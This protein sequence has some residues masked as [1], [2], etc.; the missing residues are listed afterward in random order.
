MTDLRSKY[1]P[2]IFILSAG[3]LLLLS[4]WIFLENR[5]ITQLEDML[6]ET[7]IELGRARLE[8]AR[9]R[10]P[11]PSAGEPPE[12]ENTVPDRAVPGEG[13]S[14]ADI[15]AG[16]RVI[17]HGM[18]AVDEI[19]TEGSAPLNC[20]EGFLE[21]YEAG[22]RVFE[23]DLR[24]TRDGKVVLRHDWW[25][26]DWQEGIN[27]ASVPTREEFLS[28]PIFGVYTPLSFR[29]LLLLLKEY[30]DVCIITDT[31][32]TDPDV[33]FIEFASMLAD[34]RDLGCLGLFDRIVIQLY[35]GV[36]RQCLD[37]IYPFP[38][39]IYTLYAE[40]F[41]QTAAAFRERAA[42]CAE[43]G[44]EGIVI[45]DGWWDPA[46][47]SVARE[48]GLTVYVHTVN[49]AAAARTLLESGAGAVYT[50]ILGPG[51]VA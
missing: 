20:L 28:K 22:V 11:D 19:W 32:F 7:R 36:M 13:L 4:A 38:H 34:A 46:Y 18:G 51:D 17:A 45:W 39:R 12:S 41:D 9:S 16:T 23:A 30:P 5:H 47:A 49:D 42:Y 24:L 48:Y 26:A 31:K 50:D 6:R 35:S 15:L 3:T 43:K 14:A 37:N 10:E 2:A 44:I 33:I 27:G 1:L 8:A 29:D 25:P 40:G 21:R